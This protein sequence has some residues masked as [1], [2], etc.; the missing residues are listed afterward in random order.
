MCFRNVYPLGLTS[1]KL[2]SRAVAVEVVA[3]AEL[4]TVPLLGVLSLL[5]LACAAHAV[6]VVAADVGAIVFTAGPVHVLC[7]YVVTAA[8]TLSTHTAL[9]TSTTR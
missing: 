5:A 3:L 1:A 6:S 8:F 7:G 4:S 2:V 9:V